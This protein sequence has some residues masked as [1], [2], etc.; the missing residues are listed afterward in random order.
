MK[1]CL[2][3]FFTLLGLDILTKALA[4]QYVSPILPQFFGYP[5]GGIPMFHILDVSFSLN[6]VFNTGAAWGI[7]QGYSGSL[8]LLRAS[9]ISGLIAYLIYLHRGEPNKFR[10]SLN[11]LPLWLVTTGA[12]GN[13]IDF[14]IYGHVV[15]FL[16]FCFWGHSFP[17]FNLA[18]CYITTGVLAILLLPKK[19]PIKAMPS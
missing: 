18:D 11:T 16:H 6:K 14:L 2:A 19:A 7:F 12:I 8:F 17:I 10:L 9:V 5:F 3:L 1:K 13:S 4:L 15:D